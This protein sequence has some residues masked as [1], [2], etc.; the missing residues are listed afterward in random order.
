LVD[1][2]VED[3]LATSD[4]EILAEFVEMKNNP[5]QNTEA[6]H[7]LFEKSVVKSNKSRL[8]D[9]KAGLAAD[10]AAIAPTKIVNIANVRDRLR[11]ALAACP[12]DVKLTLAARNESELSDADVQGMLQDLEE[13]GIVVPDEQSDGH[14]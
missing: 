4:Q 8:R 10:R 5:A 7:A 1:T 6:M 12:P 2:L 13:L 14:S 3:V 11:R 9:A